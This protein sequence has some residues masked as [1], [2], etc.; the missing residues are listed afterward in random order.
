MTP[1]RTDDD[2]EDETRMEPDFFDGEDVEIVS[3]EAVDE[4]GAPIE[5]AVE[6]AAA[7]PRAVRSEGSGEALASV[8]AELEALRGEHQGVLERHLRL[9]AEFDNYRR[10]RDREATEERAEGVREVLRGILPVVDNLERAVETLPVAT[11]PSVAKG[12]ELVLRQAR[13]ALREQGLEEVDALGEPFDP[14]RH[15]AMTMVLRDDF[16]D[17]QVIEQMQKGYEHGGRLLRPA[18]VKVVSNPGGAVSGEEAPAST[19][20]G[21]ESGWDG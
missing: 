7:G 1:P 8:R 9:L 11:P 16:D 20:E 2:S 3:I 14:R 10:R 17:Q 13:E 19:S 21:E 5:A 4:T 15:E 6:P 18:L 12:I